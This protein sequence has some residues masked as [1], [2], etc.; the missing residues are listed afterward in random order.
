MAQTAS[1]PFRERARS[2]FARVGERLRRSLVIRVTVYTALALSLAL[3]MIGVYVSMTIRTGLF[4]GRVEQA[5][6]DAAW[7]VSQ[8]QTRLDQASAA[9][10]EQ[11][12]GTA[13]DLVLSLLE[14]GSGIVG[15]MLLRSPDEQS[16]AVILEPIT[17][18][19][20]RNLPT[21]DLRAQVDGAAT[22]FWQSVEIPLGPVGQPGIVVGAEVQVP[23]A[24]T[25]ELYLIYTL[26]PEQAAVN[27]TMRAILVA[28]AFLVVMVAA[29]I[30]LMMWRVLRPV[31]QTA[32]SAERLAAGV[33]DVR[34]PVR[35]QDELATLA[36]SFN[37]M[38]LSLRQQINQLENLSRLQQRFVSDVSHELRTPLTTIRMAADMLY[39]S[40]DDFDP[41]TRRSAELLV[42]QLDRFESM[43]ADL[44]E[45]S[46]I[47][48]GAEL[49]ALE[50]Q[51]LRPLLRRVVELAA[52]LAERM[53]ST[54]RLN[55]LE[56]AATAVID[57]VRVER[58]L[59]NLVLNAVEHCE[60]SPID[61]TLASNESAVAVR[62]T[63]SG[64]GLSSDTA[65]HVFDR[66]WRADPARARSTGGTG[67]GLAISQE[68]ARL[69]GGSLEAWGEAGIV[70]SFLLSLPKHPGE[71]FEPPLGVVP[72][73]LVGLADGVGAP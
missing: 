43:L 41:A 59:R 26:E 18:A 58:I 72:P 64:V 4:E 68:D 69:H 31:R 16:P 19:A 38:A 29:I 46:R 70:A 49:A 25:H 20:L 34:V 36:R 23:L 39:R 65:A 8:A 47:D 12:Q 3:A 61:I 6:G 22:L 32:L 73:A 54:I 24:G 21:A 2:K 51:D 48:A 44:L 67:L 33:L 57:V 15:A 27:M 35:G 1:Q 56:H 71:T 17:N 45:I 50:E 10:V 42:A 62:V 7:R 5:L 60:G 9:T 55:G 63:D 11:V 13:Q 14:P 66:F 40:R 30:W 52:P 53:G 28:S 37:E